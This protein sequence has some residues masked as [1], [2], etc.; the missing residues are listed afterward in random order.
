MLWH[1]W[2]PSLSGKNGASP[3]AETDEEVARNQLETCMEASSAQTLLSWDFAHGFDAERVACSMPQHPNTW[4]DG[5][6][7]V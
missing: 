6:F 5:S 3:R 7:S 2:L 1:G 4:S